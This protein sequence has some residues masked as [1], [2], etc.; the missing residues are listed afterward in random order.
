MWVKEVLPSLNKNP[1][2]K[3]IEYV[4]KYEQ[5]IEKDQ[6]V[7]IKTIWQ[8]NNAFHVIPKVIGKAQAISNSNNKCAVN[9]LV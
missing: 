6:T 3:S 2:T 9:N 4:T 1:K 5:V 8:H 7:V